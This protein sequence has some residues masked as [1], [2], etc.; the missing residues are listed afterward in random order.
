MTRGAHFLM[1]YDT[2][3]YPDYPHPDFPKR[4]RGALPLSGL[5]QGEGHDTRKHHIRT[6][7]IS[8]PGDRH[9][10]FGYVCLDR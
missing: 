1:T 6:I 3:L 2:R 8:H 4:T 10:L 7:A 9:I 5:S